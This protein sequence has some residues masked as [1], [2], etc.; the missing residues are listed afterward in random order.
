MIFSI[1]NFLQV[2]FELINFEVELLNPIKLFEFHFFT[3]PLFVI[4]FKLQ[5][6]FQYII[7]IILQ[8]HGDDVHKIQRIL[9]K[10]KHIPFIILEQSLIKS[11]TPKFM[12]TLQ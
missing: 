1:A 4:I 11:R 3:Y 6:E 8:F 2:I 12:A 7:L 9:L 10:L 5:I